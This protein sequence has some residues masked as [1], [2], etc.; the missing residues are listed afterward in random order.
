MIKTTQCKFS[1]PDCLYFSSHA[2]QNYYT[3]ETHSLPG[4]SALCHPPH[5]HRRD[6]SA[7]SLNIQLVRTIS[8]CIS[9][10]LSSIAVQLLVI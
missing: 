2:S 4:R 9:I 10:S 8:Q 3:S 1:R 5:S 7:V 6:Q